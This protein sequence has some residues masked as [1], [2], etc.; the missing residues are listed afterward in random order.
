MIY[1]EDPLRRRPRESM[2]QRNRHERCVWMAGNMHK[3][4]SR[5]RKTEKSGHREAAKTIPYPR[6]R[7]C[8]MISENQEAIWGMSAYKPPPGRSW[9]NINLP[10]NYGQIEWNN[11]LGVY[12]FPDGTKYV[13]EFQKN[14]FHGRGLM[15]WN[16]KSACL[17]IFNRG[18]LE[19]KC[20]IH[21]PKRRKDRSNANRN[22]FAKG[23]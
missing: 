19:G 1:G 2:A 4:A 22:I 10:P 3:W 20:L 21:K 12:Y 5:H 15:V 9:P 11:C 6:R 16:H 7:C 17:G 14:K 23:I 13:G 18:K 8:G